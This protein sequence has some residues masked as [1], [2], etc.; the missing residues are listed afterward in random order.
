MNISSPRLLS[1][2]ADTSLVSNSTTD[3]QESVSSQS[4]QQTL[5]TSEHGG[6]TMTTTFNHNN[7]TSQP[8]HQDELKKNLKT[9]YKSNFTPFDQYV[10]NEITDSFVK[11]QA[12]PNLS[13]SNGQLCVSKSN[14][15]LANQDASS[16]NGL[17]PV[18]NAYAFEPLNNETNCAKNEP[19]YKEVVKR[20]EKANE[21]RFKSEV[22][23]NSPLSKV[24][25]SD[26]ELVRKSPCGNDPLI[27]SQIRDY[28]QATGDPSKTTFRFTPNDYKRDHLIAHMANNNNF[29]LP[30]G[31]ISANEGSTSAGKITSRRT[32]A[33]TSRPLARSTAQDR[34]RSQS[35][36][37][38]PIAT[39]SASKAQAVTKSNQTTPTKK[40]TPRVTNATARPQVSSTTVSKTNATAMTRTGV[41]SAAATHTNDVSK[42]NLVTKRPPTAA[43]TTTSKPTT[44]STSN[45]RPT[46]SS[47]QVLT[48]RATARVAAASPRVTS[49]QSSKPITPRSPV[50][51]VAPAATI[52]SSATG[53]LTSAASRSSPTVRSS[54]STSKVPSKSSP[55]STSSATTSVKSIKT[56]K[57][58]ASDQE[59]A[60]AAA[61]LA[62]EV[63]AAATAAVGSPTTG[64][65]DNSELSETKRPPTE[66]L[67]QQEVDSQPV[68]E[69]PF[70]QLQHEQYA[71]QEPNLIYT[72]TEAG[73]MLADEL[74]QAEEA[75]NKTGR[76]QA[77]QHVDMA[78]QQ[79]ES[80]TFVLKDVAFSDEDIVKNKNDNSDGLTT[81]EEPANELVNGLADGLVSAEDRF[82][83]T[84]RETSTESHENGQRYGESYNIQQG[85]NYDDEPYS[86]IPTTFEKCQPD[87]VSKQE[88]NEEEVKK[89][90]EKE[91]SQDLNDLEN[92]VEDKNELTQDD[93]LD[94]HKTVTLEHNSAAKLDEIPEQVEQH[95]VDDSK[96]NQKET[97][98]ALYQEERIVSDRSSSLSSEAS[99]GEDEI[100]DKQQVTDSKTGQPHEINLE[101]SDHDGALIENK[102]KFGSREELSSS[103]QK[104]PS[105][106]D[107][108]N[109]NQVEQESD[110]KGFDELEDKEKQY[111][112]QQYDHDDLTSK[113]SNEVDLI[114]STPED[115]ANGTT[116]QDGLPI[117]PGSGEEIANEQKNSEE[118]DYLVQEALQTTDVK[119]SP[120][121][122]DI[123]A[124]PE[125]ISPKDCD[126]GSLEHESS[127]TNSILAGGDEEEAAN[128]QGHEQQQVEVDNDDKESSVRSSDSGNELLDYGEDKDSTRNELLMNVA[129]LADVEARKRQEMARKSELARQ[130]I[131]SASSPIPPQFQSEMLLSPDQLTEQ[132][133]K[134][135]DDDYVMEQQNNDKQDNET[136]SKLNEANYTGMIPP[137]SSSSTE[138]VDKVI[139]D[140]LVGDGDSSLKATTVSQ[141]LAPKPALFDADDKQKTMTNDLLDFGSLTTNE[142]NNKVEKESREEYEQVAIGDSNGKDAE[143]GSELPHEDRNSS[144]IDFWNTKEEDTQALKEA[145]AMNLVIANDSERMNL[146][147]YDDMDSDENLKLSNHL[148]NSDDELILE[149]RSGGNDHS[150]SP[151]RIGSLSRYNEGAGLGLMTQ[152]E[153]VEVDTAKLADGSSA[154]IVAPTVAENRVEISTSKLTNMPEISQAASFINPPRLTSDEDSDEILD[155]NQGANPTDVAATMSPSS[156]VASELLRLNGE[157]ISMKNISSTT[158]ATLALDEQSISN[159]ETENTTNKHEEC[160]DL[161]STTSSTSSEAKEETVTG[162]EKPTTGH[163]NNTTKQENLDQDN[164]ALLGGAALKDKNN[165]NVTCSS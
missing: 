80:N 15:D 98:A 122:A 110:I 164:E 24:T 75:A 74:A 139:Q 25:L 88:N 105:I 21:Y 43:R 61:S 27:E 6:Q 107:E 116:I 161:L 62:T 101:L 135:S 72:T 65:E 93:S 63:K 132:F 35:S 146:G 32:P 125:A 47:V 96:L 159:N 92:E 121:P 19:W 154:E 156:S 120:E 33:A 149:P 76:Q 113:A 12:A 133:A 123:M 138:R 26:E 16:L 109:T 130:Q 127:D 81:S 10:Y 29:N 34:A 131:G 51:R 114:E 137:I 67:E 2:S 11:Q 50:K 90:Q 53:R 54:H 126:D 37:R 56:P 1:P 13:E 18:L 99:D 145:D 41:R 134:L 87:T 136:T 20:N 70:I 83:S 84:E 73:N 108:R 111:E 147:N 112:N 102:Y 22:G 158:D 49:A 28:Q 17:S 86:I 7:Q 143:V 95:I 104:I 71:T 52:P 77:D 141:D 59:K 106:I 31:Q 14:Q 38:Q 115:L 151:H 64:S 157:N 5:I 23:H 57:A 55:S 40:V 103:Y 94:S 68:K 4:D 82:D 3:I 60:A 30:K 119:A 160:A 165:A 97:S 78:R 46:H 39:S 100:I 148:T 58:L 69:E 85:Q 128:K 117:T 163:N 153:L 155:L 42:L 9:E 162:I 36:R 152:E 45:S 66:P 124:Q 118:A 44:V 140:D 91:I 129:D 79:T 142:V 144:E 89:H 48:N 8:I 150:F